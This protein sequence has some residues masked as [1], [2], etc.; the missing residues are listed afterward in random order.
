MVLELVRTVQ[1]ALAIFGMFSLAFDERDGLLCDRTVDG[2]QRWAAEIGVFYDLEVGII[3]YNNDTYMFSYVS[4]A[5]GTGV[6]TISCYA[7]PHCYHYT[8]E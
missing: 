2:M 4:K 1:S 6:G 7:P 3:A 8:Q 5:N